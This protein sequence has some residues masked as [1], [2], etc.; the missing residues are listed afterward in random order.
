MTDIV[1]LLSS[2]DPKLVHEGILQAEEL[3]T[4]GESSR[5]DHGAIANALITI[6]E[7]EPSHP[8]ASSAVWALGKLRDPNLRPTFVRFL[9]RALPQ[10][11]SRANEMW[12]TIIA[13][14]NTGEEILEQSGSFNDFDRNYRLATDYLRRLSR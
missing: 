11:E 9:A 2:A 12:Q 3:F 4:R 6:L 13:L 10:F 8:A 5:A 1:K 7:A 14:E